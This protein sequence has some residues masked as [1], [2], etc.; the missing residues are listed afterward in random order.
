MMKNAIFSMILLAALI[1]PALAM[2][3]DVT[4]PF[5]VYPSCIAPSIPIEAQSWWTEPGED[6]PRH[7]HAGACVPSARDLD[8]TLVSVGTTET[9]QVKITSHNQPGTIN[10]LRTA[11]VNT[12]YQLLDVDL[13]CQS[14]PDE[15]LTCSWIQDVTLD[16]SASAVPGLRE[17]RIAPRIDVNDLGK[18]QF[19]VL[20]AQVYLSGAGAQN[21]RTFTDPI[22]RGWYSDHDYDVARINYV[23]HFN[24]GDL[25]RTIPLVSGIVSLE[26]AHREGDTAVVSR[27]WENP[28]F[29]AYPSF[30][31]TAVVGQRSPGVAGGAQLLYEQSGN[32]T[33]TYAWDT[34][35]RIDGIHSLVVETEDTSVLGLSAGLLKVFYETSNANPCADADS[36]GVVGVQDFSIFTAEFGCTQGCQADFDGDGVVGVSDYVLFANQ[37]G[38]TCPATSL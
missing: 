6:H 29:H 28:N 5:G 13:S 18:K 20:N 23:D 10:K 37:F 14:T 7:V 4:G 11:W 25:N 33:V 26:L 15:D 16:P 32:A 12:I 2:S 1:A 35:Q 22:G 17:L 34:T 31:D 38:E 9:V 8:G 3:A 36:D 19:A 21:Y 30:H 24:G 27:L